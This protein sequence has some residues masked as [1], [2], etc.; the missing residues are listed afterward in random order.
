MLIHATMWM[1]L[2]NTTLCERSQTQKAIL[3]DSIYVKCPEQVNPWRQKMSY[4]HA[5]EYYSAL[6]KEIL[7]HAAT[8]MNLEDIMLS[9]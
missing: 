6:K 9:E 2:E 3:Y 7:S 4:I 5:V 8:W 1:N